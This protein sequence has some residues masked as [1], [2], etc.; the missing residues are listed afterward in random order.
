M[1]LFAACPSVEAQSECDHLFCYNV[2]NP[3]QNVLFYCKAVL[4]QSMSELLRDLNGVSWIDIPRDHQEGDVL[5]LRFGWIVGDCDDDGD[6][7]DRFRVSPGISLSE[8]SAA[9][10]AGHKYLRLEVAFPSNLFDGIVQH[11]SHLVMLPSAVLINQRWAQQDESFG[12]SKGLPCRE[13]IE[14]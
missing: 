2:S 11:G 13:A 14:R 7:T 1:R 9:G 4:L 10:D 8:V 3:R 5:R 6:R 12:V